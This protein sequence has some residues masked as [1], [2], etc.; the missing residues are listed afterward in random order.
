M[1]VVTI[2]EY[3]IKIPHTYR[4]Y[5]VLINHFDN[6]D[7]W[8]LVVTVLYFSRR[9]LNHYIWCLLQEKYRLIYDKKPSNDMIKW[10]RYIINI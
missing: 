4:M 8:S 9:Q 10:T 2:N 3:E 5:L 6:S 1:E 7:R